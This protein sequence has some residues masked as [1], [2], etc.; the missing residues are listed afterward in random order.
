MQVRVFLSFRSLIEGTK[1]SKK[2][3]KKAR[4]KNRKK[5]K[6]PP[7]CGRIK[8]SPKSLLN[9]KGRCFLMAYS[10]TNTYKM[11]R[12]ILNFTRKISKGLHRPEQKF[13]ADMNYGMLASDS[14]LLTEIAQQLREDTKKINTVDRLSKH[15]CCRHRVVGCPGS[16]T[17]RAFSGR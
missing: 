1:P 15:R 10:T 8:S 16:R 14:C 2:W 11:K 13:Y 6:Y 7:I 9:K 12:E 4:E 17:A 3:N 5:R